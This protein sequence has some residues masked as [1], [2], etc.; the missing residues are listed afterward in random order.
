[1]S[2]KTPE[3]A[4]A[5]LR[6]EE[7]LRLREIRSIVITSIN[8]N[9][10][11]IDD[12]VVGGPLPHKD[13][14]SNEGVVVG[15]QTRLGSV[16][17]DLALN[18]EGTEWRH[19]DEK[20]QGVVLMRKG[21]ESL[22][23]IE[24]VKAK[25]KELNEP[26]RMLP[27]VTL[28]TYYDREDLVNLTTETV[29][30]NLI[31]GI[32]LVVVILMM[33]LSNIR[34]ALIV[35]INIPVALLI[36]FSV[37]YLR[38]FSA[39]LLSIG[40][41]DF[42]IIVDAAVI[43]TENIY[44]NL[45]AG[46]FSELPLKER[47]LRC[48]RE[49]DKA[50]FFS[51]AIMICAFIPLFTM[52]GAEGE[53]FGPMAQTYACALGGA[54]LMALTLTP[55]L[56]MLLLKDVKP[57]PENL[58]VR[59]LKTRYIWQLNLCL[60]HPYITIAVMTTL[61]GVTAV[62]PMMQLGREFMPELEEGSLWIR[63]VFPVNI[64]LDA[65]KEPVA[66]ARIIMSSEPVSEQAL[67]KL[68]V[69]K[70]REFATR[71]AFLSELQRL[72]SADEL[73]RFQSR[74]LNRAFGARFKLSDES[75]A[76]LRQEVP[77]QVVAELAT[78]KDKEWGTRDEFLR[79]LI[80]V[81]S[82]DE[83][84]RYQNP[85][86]THSASSEYYK[87]TEKGLARLRAEG[88]PEISA[89]LSQV[90]RPDDGTDPGLFNNVE[91]FVPLRNEKEWPV[92]YRPNGEHKRRT[93]R[94]IVDDL[95]A[96][97][98]E[99]LPGVEWAF[100]QYIRDNVMEAISGVKG[101]NTVKIYGPDLD[102][103]EELADKVKSEMSK[104]RGLH[105]LGIYRVMGQ[106]NFEF[107]V[108]KEKCKRWGVMVADVDNVINTAV[109]GNAQTSM[110]EGEKLFDV[111]LRWP[112]NRRWDQSSILEIPV[113]IINNAQTPGLQAA[114]P[115]TLTGGSGTGPSGQ[116]SIN[117][118]PTFVSQNI[119]NY[120][121]LVPR[122][123]LKDLVTPV[124]ADG[125]PDPK[126]DFNRP[127]GSI[128]TRED[129]VR[130]IAV[131]FAVWG[132]RDLASVVNEVRDKTSHLIALPYRTRMGGEF[133]QMEDGEKRLLFY[134]PASLA[135]IFL[136][137]Y[138]AFRSLLDAFVILSNVFDLAVGGIWALYLTNTNFSM[139]AAVG[140]VSLFGVAIMEGLLMISYF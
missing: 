72:L 6:E 53:L 106:S 80:K 43:M 5:F 20:I 3:E 34:T 36:A 56:C 41:V 71:D 9:P 96:E 64:S 11:K 117:A 58:L 110:I 94:E 102:K 42:G 115:Q 12:V 40:A 55:V 19:Q 138:F 60:D 52:N 125:R 99:K 21:E 91:I 122:L 2:L 47:I 79:H 131:K 14:L 4:G 89:V 92:V 35:A 26:G 57:V 63:G 70:D 121:S 44:R 78:V 126:G 113:D 45:A 100:S 32:V 105:D 82:K 69:L 86:S 68:E 77:P 134:I 8:N 66:Q 61:I 101:D 39:N 108:D 17:Q 7:Q 97:L 24:G 67:A 120:N 74:V 75:L 136:L 116:G 114:T 90:G 65:V 18:K 10:I 25:V 112:F 62:W 129:G 1:F 130:F 84:E 95:S 73:H 140:F 139:S 135:L 85:I 15:W 109:H 118:A 27:G 132:D 38:G 54:L 16:S 50:L 98:S 119:G 51:T 23:T 133:E 88:Y 31:L 81:I 128:I 104:I 111:T 124:G 29:T 13:A 87:L 48:T 137:L 22:P 59:F 103:L 83:L 93:R 30:H 49:I 107:V 37:L 46:N 28:E 33:F 76:A 123:R 127:G